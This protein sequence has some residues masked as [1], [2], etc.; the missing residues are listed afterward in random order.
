MKP[1]SPKGNRFS[2]IY[3]EMQ[4]GKRDTWWNIS[5]SIMF[6]ATFHV[7]PRKFGLQKSLA[8]CIFHCLMR[9][10]NL[11]LIVTIFNKV[12]V[13]NERPIVAVKF[14]R[15]DPSTAIKK[16][17]F[18]VHLQKCFFLKLF[19]TQKLKFKEEDL[20]LKVLLSFSFLITNAEPLQKNVFKK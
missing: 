12:P 16:V 20:I 2:A 8:K 3:H 6:S 13:P 18:V 11:V 14:M 1:H 15:V 5:C 10:L 17:Y 19:Y 7:I 4:R 9:K